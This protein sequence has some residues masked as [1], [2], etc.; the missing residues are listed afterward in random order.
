MDSNPDKNYTENLDL[1]VQKLRK[2][3]YSLGLELQTNS[4]T[5]N[6]LITA[7]E[8]IP[9]FHIACRKPAPTVTGLIS[10]LRA[11]AASHDRLHPSTKS[12]TLF[13]DRKYHGNRN[14]SRYLPSNQF[15]YNRDNRDNRRTSRQRRKCYVCDKEDCWST[16]HTKEEREKAMVSILSKYRQYVIEEDESDGSDSKS[17]EG[18]HISDSDDFG[19]GVFLTEAVG[20]IDALEAIKQLAYQAISHALS[21]SILT[22]SIQLWPTQGHSILAADYSPTRGRYS[23]DQFHGIVI[24]TGAAFVSTAGFG[25]FLALKEQLQSS[26]E[27]TPTTGNTRFQFGIG[28]TGSKGVVRVDSPIRVLTFH[29]VDTDTLFLL[30]LHD[31]DTLGIYYNNLSNT[32]VGKDTEWPVIRKFGHPFL[33]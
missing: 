3:N 29:V 17:Q 2:L 8:A 23:K 11:A 12:D 27:I 31:L 16:R 30:S 20:D 13:T 1:L 33:I 6:K 28:T 7:Y 25:Q 15:K 19:V 18:A 22:E 21:Q 10:D 32:L 9:V 14:V 4:F 5:H 24:D 26:A